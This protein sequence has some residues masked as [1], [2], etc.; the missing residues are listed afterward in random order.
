[1]NE[2]PLTISDLHKR[3]GSAEVIRGLDLHVTENS[4]HGLVGLNGSGK[5]TTL[6][7]ILGM[8][9]FDSGRVKVLGLPPA[10]LHRAAGSVVGIFDTPSLHPG[11]TVR[12]SLQHARLLCR[13]PTRSCAEVEQLLGISAYRNY[14]VRHLSLG[15]K[16][17]AS[18]AHALL[19]DPRLI[20]LDEPFNGL[21]AEGVD[22][23][24]RLITELNRQQGTAFLL[25]S[26]QLPYLE[27]VCTHMAILHRGR[28]VMSESID[29]L[30]TRD[31]AR[32]R[33]TC[34]NPAAARSIVDQSGLAR[35]EH[36]DA[37][38]LRCVLLEGDAAA[39]NSLLVGNGLAVSELIQERDSLT[40]LFYRVT[41]GQEQGGAED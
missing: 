10:R 40:S 25:S 41:G 20:I 9:R 23:V 22:D 34:N 1:V 30:F 8:Q 14:R 26:H 17:R 7:C 19:G 13:N 39:V 21:D 29:S 15:N 36:L 33:L 11:L 35:V 16:R 37:D 12:Q 4:I 28:I 5:T 38:K 2:V 24:L 32:I 27:Q 31:H 18:I 3:Y 6:E